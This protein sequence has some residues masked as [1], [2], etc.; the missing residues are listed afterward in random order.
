[1][2][3][4]RIHQLQQAMR[5]RDVDLCVVAAGDSLRYLLGYRA[6]AVERLTALLVAREGA[7]MVLPYFDAPEFSAAL[8]RPEVIPW[9]DRSGPAAAVDAAFA[10]L[11]SPAG[12]ALVDDELPF[13]F[14]V[15][16]R[17][18]L[19]A[20]PGSARGLLTELRATKSADELEL[21]ARAGELVSRGIDF[22]LD[23]VR[24]GMTERDLALRVADLLWE[25]GADSVDLVL[26][27]AGANSANAHHLADR[28]P[29]KAGEPVLVDIAACMGGYF[30]DITQQVHLGEPSEEYQA[31]Y[32]VVRRAQQ[33]GV[34]AAVAGATAHDVA[35]AATQAILDAGLGAYN[36]PRTG[37]GI[38]G[39]MH[40]EPSVVEGND[41]TLREGTV[42]TVEPGV[43]IPGRYG[44]R[45]E[46]TVAVTAE[47]PRRLTRG[48]RPLFHRE[49]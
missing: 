15:Q 47:G 33:C 1:M 18:R 19:G 39:S 12:V 27:Q 21:I 3:V 42:I 38:G 35:S 25:G 8:G 26:V 17:N 10:A 2:T 43:Y 28:T 6:M 7:V 45:I 22:A 44:I 48:S 29:L 46:D 32:E 14:F 41:A 24:P 40:E 4:D 13:G 37:H 34:E 5:R 23:A 30:A 36:G 20:Q 9:T 49:P 31:H 11:G 16:L